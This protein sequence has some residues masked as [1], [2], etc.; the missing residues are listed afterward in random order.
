MKTSATTTK[1]YFLALTLPLLHGGTANALTPPEVFTKVSPSVWGVT[2]YDKDGLKLSSGSAV[3]IAPELLATNCHVL[4]KASRIAVTSDNVSIGATLD[5]W[6]T[7]RDICQLKARNLKA[8]AVKIGAS[9]TLQVGQAVF[10]IGN[11]L[12]LELTLGSGLISSLRKNDQSQ[13]EAIQTSTPISAGSSGGGLFDDQA[14][15]IGITTFQAKEGQNLNFAIPVEWLK[16]LPARHAAARLAEEKNPVSTKPSPQSTAAAAVKQWRYQFSG[17][18]GKR[19]EI[20][21][22]EKDAG[23]ESATEEVKIGE[24]TL[25]SLQWQKNSL[26]R[27]RTG[28]GVEWAEVSPE[29]FKQGRAN[30]SLRGRPLL[31]D[32]YNLSLRYYGETRVMIAGKPYS[33]T[34]LEIRGN[35]EQIP[36]I[37]AL[38]S[39]TIQAWYSQELGRV[40]KTQFTMNQM[41]GQ[42]ADRTETSL[43]AIP[44]Q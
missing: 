40:I 12:G 20:V 30:H 31:G 14:R 23:N 5:M 11:P 10:S 21:V 29:L 41:N 1:L 4:R 2:T 3:V 15:L 7:V 16:E 8:P 6:D 18:H 34:R 44:E 38:Y 17:L 36:D 37:R 25:D 32:Y 13:L 35:K 27:M 26:F 24:Q 22:L 19:K 42:I 33:A 43:V 9:A 28:D 39:F